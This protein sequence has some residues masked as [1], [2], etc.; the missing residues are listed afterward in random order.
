MKNFRTSIRIGTWLNDPQK[1]SERWLGR[2]CVIAAWLGLALALVSPP[3]GSPIQLCWQQSAT[4]IP[5]VGCG[6]T[7]S[8]SCGIRGMMHVR[9]RLHRHM[10]GRAAVF[11]GFYLAFIIV[12]I[13]YGLGRALGQ[14]AGRLTFL[15]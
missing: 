9:D 13:A 14:C 6:I 3:H 2:P 5:C 11:N 15:F 12:F 1:V 8:L 4:G 7:R 10:R